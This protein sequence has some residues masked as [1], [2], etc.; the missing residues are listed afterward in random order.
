[1][2]CTWELYAFA[3]NLRMRPWLVSLNNVPVSFIYLFMKNAGLILILIGTVC[4]GIGIFLYAGGNLSWVG[5][6][7]GDIRIV[8]PGYRIYFPITTSIL[9]SVVLSVIFYLIRMLR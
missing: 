9:I 5:K 2:Q 8:R 3:K 1:M 6:L 7:P 4:A